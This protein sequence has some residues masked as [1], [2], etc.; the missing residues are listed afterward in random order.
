MKLF[1]VRMS[2]VAM[3]W[4][5]DSENALETAKE[6]HRDI[7]S[8]TGERERTFELLCENVRADQLALFG[9]DGQCLP[10]GHDGNTRIKDLAL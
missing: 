4:A 7:D 6:C 9:W 8:D 5:P 3:I 1:A 10:Y 2:V